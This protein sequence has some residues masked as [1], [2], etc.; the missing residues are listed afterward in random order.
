MP[1]TVNITVV[2]NGEI[3]TFRCD[4]TK[5]VGW[6]EDKIRSKYGLKYGGIT[7]DDVDQDSD[8]EFEFMNDGILRF[9]DGERS[10]KYPASRLSI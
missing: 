8:V 2:L 1:S 4:A 6:A 7:L 9:V 3:K 5:T 10:G